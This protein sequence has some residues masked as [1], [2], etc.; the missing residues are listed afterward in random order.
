MW[1]GPRNLSTALLRAFENRTD[2][3]VV[4]EPFYACFLDATG[5]DHPGRAETLAVC[6]R[7]A[8][9]VAAALIG[10]VP[11]SAPIFYQKHMTHHMVPALPLDWMASVR[12]AFLIRDP[13][14]VILSYAVRRPDLDA[15]DI[16]FVRQTELFDQVCELTGEVPAVIDA[17]DVL[18]DPRATLSALCSRLCI[19]FDEAMLAWP[20]GPRTTDG[21]WAQ[22]WYDAV[23][24]STG[25]APYRPQRRALPERYRKIEELCRPHYERMAMH[26]LRSD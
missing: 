5:I 16:G 2:T 14:D 15:E 24:A 3:A 11:G 21:V 22:Y 12:H 23:E 17:R 20:A 19:P 1:S 6:E 26:A 8:E 7:D 10:D 25:F 13:V 18:R 9:R 4:D